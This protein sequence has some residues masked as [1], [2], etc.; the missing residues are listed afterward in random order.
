MHE[1]HNF[2]V[3]FDDSKPDKDHLIVYD[4]EKYSLKCFNNETGELIENDKNGVKWP[5]VD[6]QFM[7][8]NVPNRTSGEIEVA[9]PAFK[10]FHYPLDLVFPLRYSKMEAIEIFAPYQVKDILSR[11]YDISRCRQ[12]SGSTNIILFYFFF[13]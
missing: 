1:V 2:A 9:D 5:F 7:V 8:L 10:D 6:L 4:E 13:F 11:N 3:I 12:N